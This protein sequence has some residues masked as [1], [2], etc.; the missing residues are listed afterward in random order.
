MKRVVM[1]AALIIWSTVA[2]AVVYKWIDADGHVHYGDQPPDGVKAE[3]VELLGT[4][5]HSGVP[6]AHPALAARA[7]PQAAAAA[8]A[9]AKEKQLDPAEAA[10]L[11][12]QQCSD[13]KARLKQ[14]MEGR[15]LFKAGPNG[16]HEYLTSDQIDSERADAKKE[17][18]T[19]CAGAN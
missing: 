14:L 2:S 7:A 8:A 3:I 15:H 10:A 4:G 5:T 18:D 11:R 19:V 6:A 12:D 9:G 13:A 17:V 1:F 16:E